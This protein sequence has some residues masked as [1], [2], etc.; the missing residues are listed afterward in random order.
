MAATRRSSGEAARL[1]PLER[2][3][4]RREPLVAGIGLASLTH[5]CIVELHG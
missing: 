1:L 2:R 3:R 4:L 5:G